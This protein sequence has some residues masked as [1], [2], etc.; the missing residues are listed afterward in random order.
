MEINSQIYESKLKGRYLMFAF[1]L[2]SVFH[3]CLCL[4]LLQETTIDTIDDDKVTKLLPCRVLSGFMFSLAKN[5][6]TL[7]KKP[8]QFK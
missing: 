5:I 6:Y 2:C 8:R 1:E 4:I 7:K 3:L